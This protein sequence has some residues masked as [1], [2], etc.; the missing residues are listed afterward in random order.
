MTAL[1]EIPSTGQKLKAVLTNALPRQARTQLPKRIT[2]T[3]ENQDQ[4]SEVLARVIQLTVVSTMTILYLISPK[5]D[6]G[7][8][9]SPVPYAL[10]VY[11]ILNIVGL[12]W[13]LN[14]GLPNWAVYGS[15]VFDMSLLMVLIWS[16]HVQYQQPPSFYLKAPTVL[17]IFIFIAIRALRFESRFV[18]AAGI[19]AALGWIAMVVYVITVDPENTMITRNYVEYLTSNSVLIGAE[20]DKIISII[21]VTGILTLALKRA[22]A[23]LVTATSEQE[24]ARDLSRFFDQSVASRITGSDDA[25]A[26]G[27]GTTREA[28]I[29]NIDIRGFTPMAADM[30]AGDVMKVL[31]AYQKQIVPIIQ[32]HGGRIWAENIPQGGACINLTLPSAEI[33]S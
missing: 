30:R 15:I 28:A 31:A 23:L 5:T 4:A 12:Y 2:R 21:L 32:A 9:F 14:R 19:T 25:I 27:E 1:Q 20:L 17:Y 29:M 11:F 26:A 10:A 7:T 16:F 13:A 33:R 6:A 18:L 24:A 22:H 8:A 3:I